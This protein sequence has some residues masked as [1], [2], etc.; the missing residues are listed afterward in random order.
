MLLEYRHYLFGTFL[1]DTFDCFYILF[2]FSKIDGGRIFLQFVCITNEKRLKL[3][4]AHFLY[5]TVGIAVDYL[6]F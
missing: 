2:N 6:L 5:C 1:T 3:L 4:T